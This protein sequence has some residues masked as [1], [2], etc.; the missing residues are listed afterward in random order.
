[1]SGYDDVHKRIAEDAHLWL[2]EIG[3]ERLGPAGKLLVHLPLRD[4]IER[5]DT[6][7]T[8]VDGTG[9]SETGPIQPPLLES[10]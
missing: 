1:M 3:Y 8:P 6:R 5:G 10:Q 7:L 9:R 2:Q 4:E